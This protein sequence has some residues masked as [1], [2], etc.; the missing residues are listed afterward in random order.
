MA[1]DIDPIAHNR[2]AWDKQVDA[3]RVLRPGGSLLAGFMNP[4]PFIFDRAAEE[5]RGEL[6]VR[7]SLPYSDLANLSAD[8]RAKLVGESPLEYGHTM[9]DQIGGQLAAGLVITGFTETGHHASITA[10]YMPGYYATR[11]IK[12]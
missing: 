12:P 1:A 6:N 5:D 9:T 11:A 7:H 10:K 2:T 8:E 4:D 3:G